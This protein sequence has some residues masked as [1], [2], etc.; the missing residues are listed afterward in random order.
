MKVIAGAAIVLLFA[1]CDAEPVRTQPNSEGSTS[2]VLSRSGEQ[3]EDAI[4]RARQFFAILD[5]EDLLG[6]SPDAIDYDG[7][8]LEHDPRAKTNPT[9]LAWPDDSLSATS[10]TLRTL[11]LNERGEIADYRNDVLFALAAARVAARTTRMESEWPI[12]IPDGDV[13]ESHFAAADSPVAQAWKAHAAEIARREAAYPKPNALSPSDICDLGCRL[14]RRFEPTRW[15]DYRSVG[16][17]VSTR[18]GFTTTGMGVEVPTGGIQFLG[19]VHG[20]AS[21][22]DWYY[23]TFDGVSGK[24][25]SMS[26]YNAPATFPSPDEIKFDAEAGRAKVVDHVDSV[27]TFGINSVD[28]RFV[29][30]LLTFELTEDESDYELSKPIIAHKYVLNTNQSTWGEALVDAQTG[31]I[32]RWSHWK[33]TAGPEFW[34]KLDEDRRRNGSCSCAEVGTDAE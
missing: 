9:R 14:L 22:V 34:N 32:V 1:G 25:L 33:L 3:R 21:E 29:E 17:G 15:Q 5:G 10:R 11:G 28:A 31:E 2:P 23:F 12:K 4:A 8:A 30:T 20:I 6:E 26:R 7:A 18:W 27:Y 16:G 19:T 24:L 13:L